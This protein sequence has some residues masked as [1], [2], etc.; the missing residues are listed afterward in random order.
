MEKL[1]IHYFQHVAFEGLGCIENWI[2]E[3]QHN[4]T[5]T[6]FFQ[7]DSLPEIDNID[8]LIVL[9]GPMGVHDEDLYPWLQYEK[10]FLKR[11]I[12]AN[13]IVIGICLGA[14]LI[15]DVLGAKVYPNQYKE[16]GWLDVSLTPEGSK[17]ALFE[18][19]N[20]TIK[21]FQWH[22]DTFDLPN[23]AK[24]LFL[25]K[26]CKIQCYL[27]KTNVLGLQFH[28]EITEECLKEMINHG[29]HEL[30]QAKYV[31]NEESILAQSEF[32]KSNND[33]MFRVLENLSTL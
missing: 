26:A 19:F 10:T 15:A 17:T 22:G 32:I 12:D 33:M 11:A 21:V 29:K 3:K 7:N 20:E 23:G 16:I 5:Y 24:H 28:F 4:L 9:G 8:W 31:Q 25:S 30:K 27:N 6:K 2:S 14:Q 18:G 13:K 1:R